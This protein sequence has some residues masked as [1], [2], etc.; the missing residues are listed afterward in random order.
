MT[1]SNSWDKDSKS[2]KKAVLYAEIG[3]VQRHK[4]RDAF[5]DELKKRRTLLKTRIQKKKGGK[6]TNAGVNVN[7]K[8]P[9]P[10]GSKEELWTCYDNEELGM[11]EEYKAKYAFAPLHELDTDHNRKL[12]HKKTLVDFFNN[13]IIEIKHNWVE[14]QFQIETKFFDPLNVSEEQF[15]AARS[16]YFNKQYLE[17]SMY[18]PS[19]E[20]L[21]DAW[22]YNCY[23][24]LY[25]L[26]EEETGDLVSR[27]L[28][29]SN[30]KPDASY[31]YAY[32]DGRIK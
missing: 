5:I 19:K 10:I 28:R 1:H 9:F 26:W 4:M 25:I 12:E 32:W 21:E 31:K 24:V 11:L 2:F 20:V 7:G 13:R 3:I 23:A 30:G 27:V 18:K 29:K 16:E 22:E 15:A 8:V 6:I 14:E 17:V